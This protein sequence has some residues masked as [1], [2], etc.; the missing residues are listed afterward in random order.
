MQKKKTLMPVSMM[1]ND[2][3][4]RLCFAHLRMMLCVKH[5]KSDREMVGII[6]QFTA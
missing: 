4:K 2:I 6:R 3:V 1:M 5:R